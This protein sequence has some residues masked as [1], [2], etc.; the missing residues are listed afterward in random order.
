MPAKPRAPRAARVAKPTPSAQQTR[1]LKASDRREVWRHD[2]GRCGFVGEDGHCCN[3][4]R[5]LQFAHKEPWAKGGPNTADNLGLRCPTHNALEADR[6]Y[7]ARFMMKKRT[8]KPLKVRESI[9]RYVL[10]GKP[11]A[12]LVDVERAQR[13][14]GGV[15]YTADP[16]S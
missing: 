14:P 13:A 4:T 2:E 16:L 7:G 5:G 10:R 3:E 1:H 9:A 8:Q 12:A 11:C 6:D 15:S